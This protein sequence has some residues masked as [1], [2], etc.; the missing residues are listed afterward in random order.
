[1]S[2]SLSQNEAGRQKGCKK[3]GLRP[4]GIAN[5]RNLFR[6]RLNEISQ[7]SRAVLKALAKGR[8]YQQILAADRTL[9]PHDV[10][11]ALSESPTRFWEKRSSSKTNHERSDK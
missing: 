11:R 7:K 9:T 2:P 5:A 4:S 1:M 8:S 10:F 3:V 6:M